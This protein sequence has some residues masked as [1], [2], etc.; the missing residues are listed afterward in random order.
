MGDSAVATRSRSLFHFLQGT[1][2]GS[3]TES[4]IHPAKRHPPHR[5]RTG[6][7]ESEKHLLKGTFALSNVTPRARGRA[8]MSVTDLQ[9][10]S[11]SPP[12]GERYREG[13]PRSYVKACRRAIL[14]Q[15]T[16]SLD[17]SQNAKPYRNRSLALSLTSSFAAPCPDVNR[18]PLAMATG[19]WSTLPITSSDAAATS[20]ATAILVTAITFD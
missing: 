18:I 6:V 19:I 5:D 7:S 15:C 8:G 2:S 17:T 4:S 16:H 13:V 14:C 9:A 11:I 10:R 20:S 12:P 1:D 3:D